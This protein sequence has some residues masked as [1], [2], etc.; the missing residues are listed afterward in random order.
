ML[1]GIVLLAAL[2]AMT[3]I[4]WTS[5]DARSRA[6]TEAIYQLSIVLHSL[7]VAQRTITGQAMNLL[8][9]LAAAEPVRSQ[10]MPAAS[11]LFASILREHSNSPTCL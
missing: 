2:P 10:D 4:V 11:V 1:V 6:K 8:G 3:A 7:A 5:F 9:I